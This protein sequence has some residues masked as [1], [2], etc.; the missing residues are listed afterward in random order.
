M[1][2]LLAI[3]LLLTSAIYAQDE[4]EQAYVKPDFKAIEQ[5][6]KNKQSALYYQKLFE[7]FQQA[8]STLTLEE[9][10][11]LYFGYSFT[12]AYK[13]YFSSDNLK[14]IRT[15]VNT[16]N[17]TKE[18]MERVIELSQDAINGYPFDVSMMGYRAY[19]YRALGKE[20]LAEKEEIRANL[21]FDAILGT[22]DGMSKETCFY[23][24]NVGNEYE[25]INVLGMAYA[26]EQ[27][28]VEGKYDYLE[29]EENDYGVYGLYFNVSRIMSSFK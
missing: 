19:F 11:H 2:K 1:R 17:L 5:N 20:K 6:I 29:L 22:G 10:Y 24:I 25:L 21:V 16:D 27:K 14:E 12:D 18:Q 3:L 28:L 4:Q 8:D 13:P 26:G 15:L 23:V 9:K 7:R